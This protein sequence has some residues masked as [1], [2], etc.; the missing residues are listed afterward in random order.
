[1][2]PRHWI[3]CITLLAPVDTAC[4]HHQT[5][6]QALSNRQ[7][8]NPSC[9]MQRFFGSIL[10]ADAFVACLQSVSGKLA[11]KLSNPRGL[12]MMMLVVLQCYPCA[13]PMT[14]AKKMSNSRCEADLWGCLACQ[15]CWLQV[16]QSCPAACNSFIRSLV[17]ARSC[18]LFKPYPL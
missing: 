17:M 14:I 15:P 4:R 2:F 11:K 13:Q 5:C 3:D 8:C 6:R 1:M 12:N 10:A 9:R 16:G 18:S 7:T